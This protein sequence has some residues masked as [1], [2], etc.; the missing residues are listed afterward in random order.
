[1]T[2]VRRGRAIVA[3][4][5]GLLLAPAARA[6]SDWAA[7]DALPGPERAQRLIGGAKKEGELTLYGSMQVVSYS[8]LQKAFEQAYGVKIRLWRGAGAEILQRTVSEAKASRADFDAAETDGFA[9][10]TMHREG[11]LAPVKSPYHADLIPEAVRP[12]GEWV[13]TR[14]N[15]SAGAY[16]TSVM[17]PAD[18]PKTFPD[19]L[20][21]RFKGQLGIEAD[22]YDWFGITMNLLGEEK[23]LALFRQLV[24]TNGLSIRRGHTLLTN[25]VAAGEVTIG[26]DVY[27][28]NV[29]VAKKTGAPVDWFLISPAVARFNG[30]AVAKRAPHPYAARLFYDF[31]LNEGQRIM[32]QREFVPASR[33][34]RSVLDRVTLNFADPGVVID[35]GEKW[36]RLYSEVV[37]SGRR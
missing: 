23:G 35:Q 29:D 27:M 25:L 17:K 36:Q 28:Q 3:F 18:L 37:R 33:K 14:V 6:Q 31:M 9:L 32:L 12:H 34:V 13:G 11:L 22:D 30:I 1:M 7:L 8:F 4:A 19:L 24:A 26:L 20:A 2:R 21:P 15:I 5:I 16:N 10:E